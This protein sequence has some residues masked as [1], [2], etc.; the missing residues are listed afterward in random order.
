MK[1]YYDLVTKKNVLT[2]ATGAT[3]IYL[4]SKTLLSMFRSPPYNP[5]QMNFTNLAIEYYPVASARANVPGELRRLLLSLSPNLDDNSKRTTLHTITQ[6]IYLKESEAN[7]CTNDDIRLV[8]LFLDDGDKAVKTEAL[9]ALKAFTAVW[10]FKIKIQEYVP[11]IIELV[12]SSWDPTLQV[13]G[14][15]LLNGLNIPDNTH[16]LLRGMLP[17]FLE[18]LLMA[19]TFAQVQVLKLLSTLAQK[20]DLLYDIMNC[21]TP[22]EF[23]SLFQPSL[24]GNMLYEMLVFVERLS[25]GRLSPQYQSMQWQ[26]GDNSLHETIFG[27]NSRLSDRL[28]ALII[29]PEEEV[30]AQACKVILSLRLNREES[31]VVSAPAFGAN[32]SVHPLEST[33]ISQV[34]NPSDLSNQ[35]LSP[36]NVP[37]EPTGTNVS[38][39]ST[40]DNSGRS[41]HTI[42]GT[43]ETGHSFY[44]LPRADHSFYP[45][46]TVSSHIVQDQRD[47]SFNIP[48]PCYSGESDN[49]V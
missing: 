5:D 25:E 14:L 12:T 26:Y 43:D 8:A 44:P 30:Q 24:P 29:H 28:L 21:R 36:N 6:C 35:P 13:A 9:H 1:K 34:S 47:N 11:K 46:E 42:L 45:L 10:R 18:I 31:K 37:S 20:E 17:N 38:F 16:T 40:H 23:L 19:N 41:F 49:G 3:A 22:A 7:A 15:R 27:N 33:R 48:P 2:A 32:I 4:V 39:D